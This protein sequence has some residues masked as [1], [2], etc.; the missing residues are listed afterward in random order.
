VS[1]SGLR[2]NPPHELLNVTEREYLESLDRFRLSPQGEAM[3]P[4]PHVREWFCMHGG[5][6][7]HIA[8][9]A[10]PFSTVPCVADWIFRHFGAWVRAFGFVPA[11]RPGVNLPAYDER[12]AGWLEWIGSGDILVDDNAGNIREAAAGGLKTVLMP[13]PWNGGATTIEGALEELSR[14]AGA[15]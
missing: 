12:K 3:E 14:M 9:T 7:R 1:F 13:Q 11:V 6:C 2:R 10:R 4:E 15:V 5:R 8:L